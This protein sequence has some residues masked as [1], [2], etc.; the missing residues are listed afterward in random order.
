MTKGRIG[1]YD[2]ETQHVWEVV[3]NMVRSRGI[4]QY[5]TRWKYHENNGSRIRH[6]I[7]EIAERLRAYHLHSMLFDLRGDGSRYVPTIQQKRARAEEDAEEERGL[8]KRS[9]RWSAREKENALRR[10]TVFSYDTRTGVGT[11]TFYSFSN[12]SLSDD[13][14]QKRKAILA[15]ELRDTLR[16]WETRRPVGLTGL[17][18]D[19]RR[20]S[21]G[22]MYPIMLGMAPYL[23][24]TPLYAIVK[25]M[26][27]PDTNARVW[28]T[29][30]KSIGISETVWKSNDD[31]PKVRHDG[32]KVTLPRADKVPI[33]V[34]IGK[35]TSSAGEFAA[36]MFVGKR[37][38]RSFGSLT[39]GEY[40]SYNEWHDVHR[41]FGVA[42]TEGLVVLSD[43]TIVEGSLH[44]D[45]ITRNPMRSAKLWLRTT[46]DIT[47]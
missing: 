42:I 8:K 37:G 27:A 45:I 30:P 1:S 34:L 2:D 28:L 22:S 13:E 17:V 23:E 46:R 19:F 10:P 14:F 6:G 15:S 32:K 29:I 9:R 20:H 7:Y 39:D 31:L 16:D 18:L 12:L 33:A 38:A 43:G 26:D 41:R 21:G 36:A 11:I 5:V 25:T 3:A 24:G 40:F 4:P 35:D 47:A 44:P